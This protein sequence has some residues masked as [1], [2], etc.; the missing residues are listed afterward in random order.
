[1]SA[2][3]G[4]RA[5]GRLSAW[6][7]LTLSVTYLRVLGEEQLADRGL[8]SPFAGPID[9]AA[10]ALVAVGALTA[11][12][13]RVVLAD[14]G[15]EA[16]DMGAG[17]GLTDGG[18]R[19]VALGADVRLSSGTS[20]LS[21]ARLSDDETAIAANYRAD[22]QHAGVHRDWIRVPSGWPSGLPPLVL[23]DDRGAKVAL[24]FHG[25]G[26]DDRWQATLRAESPV[27]P[28]TAWIEF[29]DARI[30]CIDNRP[31]VR[32]AIEPLRDGNP[33][34]TYLRRDLARSEPDFDSGALRRR[35]TR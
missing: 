24:T 30:R 1:M 26:N 27:A 3:E 11:D 9:H 16:D 4:P 23:A 13:A 28:D 21:H 10:A 6:S 2:A 8:D 17:D 33:A 7:T 31:A 25:S 35:S 34:H 5:C 12:D 14:Y 18:C 22:P 29:C 19:V 32:V 15:L 20:R